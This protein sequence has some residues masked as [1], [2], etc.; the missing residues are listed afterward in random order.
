MHFRQA[1]IGGK[2]AS[3]IG[4]RDDDTGIDT[5]ITTYKTA[6]TDAA[7]ELLGKTVL[8]K[9]LGSSKMFSISVMRGEI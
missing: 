3:L 8:E 9:I 4:M 1:T 2:F 6:L 5:M 7:S